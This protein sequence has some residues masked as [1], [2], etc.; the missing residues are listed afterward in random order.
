MNI[1]SHPILDT[2]R[3]HH[4]PPVYQRLFELHAEAQAMFRS[5]AASW[6]GIDARI[7]DPRLRR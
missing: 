6:R 4:A 3:P 7:D 2:A 1:A 5:K